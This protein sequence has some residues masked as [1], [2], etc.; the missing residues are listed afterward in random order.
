MRG[1]VHAVQR[2]WAVEDDEEDLRGGEVGGVEEG[3]GGGRGRGW[4]GE[5]WG[6]GHCIVCCDSV[7]RWIDRWN[8]SAAGWGEG[9]EMSS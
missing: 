1:D 7:D 8:C 4:G 3:V 9:G 5:G 2:L 6:E